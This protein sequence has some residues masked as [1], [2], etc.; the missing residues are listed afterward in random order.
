MPFEAKTEGM[1]ESS[2]PVTVGHEATGWVVEVGSE[3]KGFKESDP[4]G[5]IP[6]YGCCYECS[7]CLNVYVTSPIF[8]ANY[9][10]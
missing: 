6:A 3:V 1:V 7:N 5:F 10:S 2:A 4:V 8:H 9:S